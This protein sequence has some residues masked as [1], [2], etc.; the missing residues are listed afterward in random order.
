MVGIY[1]YGCSQPCLYITRRAA[2]V[3]RLRRAMLCGTVQCHWRRTLLALSGR[4]MQRDSR[5]QELFGMPVWKIQ[6]QR[7]QHL[8]YRNSPAQ[9]RRHLLQYLPSRNLPA[10]YGANE[11]HRCAVG[12]AQ[13]FAGSSRATNAYRERF[14]AW[15]AKRNALTLVLEPSKRPPVQNPAQPA[16]PELSKAQPERQPAISARLEPTPLLRAPRYLPRARLERSPTLGLTH[17]PQFPAPAQP[18]RFYPSGAES[19]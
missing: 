3:I 13:N 19:R 1:D 7:L 14:K 11:L 10:P 15:R 5:K 16:L 6:Q 8:F 4:S 12:T 17:A 2:W 18:Y 9:C